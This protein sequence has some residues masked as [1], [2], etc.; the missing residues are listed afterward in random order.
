MAMAGHRIDELGGHAAGIILLTDD[1]PLI[2]CV[3][4]TFL[5]GPAC[6]ISSE[7]CRAQKPAPCASG[8]DGL[9]MFVGLFHKFDGVVL[10]LER[11]DALVPTWD[12]DGIEEDGTRGEK[13]KSM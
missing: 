7:A 6:G 8:C 3:L 1:E 5:L 2:L 13:L 10:L 4:I 9:A 12:I 11:L